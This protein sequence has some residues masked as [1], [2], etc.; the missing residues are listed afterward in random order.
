MDNV[1]ENLK[2]LEENFF[3][4]KGEF[5]RFDLSSIPE[6]YIEVSDSCYLRLVKEGIYSEGKEEFE[7]DMMSSVAKEEWGK[8]HVFFFY[9]DD[10]SELPKHYH[11]RTE[12]M[13]IIKGSF[14]DLISG[15]F[16]V[17]KV[18]PELKF[19]AYTAHH[20]KIYEPSK[21]VIFYD[22]I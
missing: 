14:E 4:P 19:P 16:Y 3:K 15:K 7:E 8:Y 21:I 13:R 22:K 17:N 18:N 12:S 6:N 11:D 20:P 5:W 2:K 9:T 1:F 10:A